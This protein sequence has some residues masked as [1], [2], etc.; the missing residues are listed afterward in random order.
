MAHIINTPASV[1]GETHIAEGMSFAA[2]DFS[3]ADSFAS[4]SKGGKNDLVERMRA[5]NRRNGTSTPMRNPLAT[6]R[7]ITAPAFIIAGDR[8]I[9]THVHTVAI[10]RNLRR[11]WLWIVPNSGHATLREHADEFNQKVDEF[12]QAKAIP[13]LAH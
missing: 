8:D 11:A 7:Q 9:I 13:A 4:P 6:L 12:F 1:Y 5:T 10:Y 3:V 2:P